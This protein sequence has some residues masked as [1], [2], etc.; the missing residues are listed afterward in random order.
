MNDTNLLENQP[1]AWTPTPD[2]IERAQ[3]TRFMK[4][5]NV[6]TFDELYKFSIENVELFTFEV[7]KFLDIRFNP[8]YEKLLDLSDGAA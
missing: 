6:S 8:P 2:V 4:Q 3:L 7:L 1:I 5:V